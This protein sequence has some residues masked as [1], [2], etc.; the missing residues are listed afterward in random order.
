MED[1]AARL[2]SVLVPVDGS[3]ASLEALTLAC[4]VAKRNKGKVYAIYTIV[5]HRSLPLDAQLAAEAQQGEEVLSRAEAV[6][7]GLDFRV[8]GE[9]LQAR[10]AGHAIVDEAIE[11]GVDA[12][13][14]GVEYSNPFGMFEL[15]VDVEYIL[16]HAHCEV[17][18][19]RRAGASGEGG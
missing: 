7:D 8:E 2:K 6:A 15:G 5:V 19:C 9:L 4:L 11:R 1:L 14:M 18:L 16:K 12:I 17:W 13:F 10:D 3:Q